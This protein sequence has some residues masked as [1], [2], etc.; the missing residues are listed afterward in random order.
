M[1]FEVRVLAQLID[2]DE[3]AAMA[4]GCAQFGATVATSS[5]N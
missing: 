2:A 1:H 5:P 4:C 3:D